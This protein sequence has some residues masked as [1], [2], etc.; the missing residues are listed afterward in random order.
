MAPQ[1]G[2][3]G[4]KYPHVPL[5][6]SLTS[7]AASHWLIPTRSWRARG[8]YG[9]THVAGLPGPE[10]A[11]KG[12]R[13]GLGKQE[14]SGSFLVHRSY[15]FTPGGIGGP[16][17]IK[18]IDISVVKHRN[19]STVWHKRKQPLIKTDTIAK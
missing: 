17:T 18:H 14:T 19:I 9:R 7:V 15:F 3:Q 2:S 10:Q 13:V 6:L 5:L 12:Q 1:Q 8:A 11:K 4:N 16:H